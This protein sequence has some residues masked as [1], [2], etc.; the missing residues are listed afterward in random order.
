MALSSLDINL[1]ISVSLMG[2]VEIPLLGIS[3]LLV[4]LNIS[5]VYQPCAFS[6][7]RIAWLYPLLISLLINAFGDTRSMELLSVLCMYSGLLSSEQH[8]SE[9]PVRVL[10]SEGAR[11][12]QRQHA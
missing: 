5:E 12:I 7:L 1:N 8:V 3:S 11:G 9:W 2:E 4:R 6:L 10:L